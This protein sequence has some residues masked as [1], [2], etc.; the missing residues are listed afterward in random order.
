MCGIAALGTGGGLLTGPERIGGLR[1]PGGSGGMDSGRAG[2]LIRRAW[3]K[4]RACSEGLGIVGLGVLVERRA[5][6]TGD[7][8]PRRAPPFVAQSPHWGVASR[9]DLRYPL[10]HAANSAPPPRPRP[11]PRPERM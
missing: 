1:A 8:R 3:R 10:L 6:R 4:P 7:S 2:R 5:L 9:E 11:H